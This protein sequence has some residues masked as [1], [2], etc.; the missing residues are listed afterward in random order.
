MSRLPVLAGVAAFASLVGVTSTSDSD[1]WAVGSQNGRPGKGVGAKPLIDHWDG[2]AW[3]QVTTP[4][5]P[6]QR[7]A[8]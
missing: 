8:W 1:A 7:E 3:S 6:R 4:A 2:A 5:T